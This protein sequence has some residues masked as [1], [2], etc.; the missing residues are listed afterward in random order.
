MDLVQRQAAVMQG[1]H[2]FGGAEKTLVP[3]DKL[4]IQ[5]AGPSAEILLFAGPP[6]GKKWTVVI[7]V[8]VKE[9]PE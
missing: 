5:I 2:S 6:V 3:D 9:E 7:N 1:E 4:K 8:F